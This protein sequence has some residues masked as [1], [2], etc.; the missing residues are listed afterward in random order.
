V[1]LK[2]EF[3]ALHE[4]WN[5]QVGLKKLESY[6]GRSDEPNS[7]Y[8][9][10]TDGDDKDTVTSAQG[11]KLRSTIHSI[12]SPIGY[13]SRSRLRQETMPKT[14][15]VSL[16]TLSR[17]IRW[18]DKSFMTP[19]CLSLISDPG[20]PGYPQEK[21]SVV[22]VPIRRENSAESYPVILCPVLWNKKMPSKISKIT[23]IRILCLQEVHVLW[24]SVLKPWT[25]QTRQ[26]IPNL[27]GEIKENPVW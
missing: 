25:P 15:V 17:A 3:P 22:D 12:L 23:N 6:F 21:V 4:I 11:Y 14:S 8:S 16:Q 5:P 27:W 2:A 18:T 19:S 13:R 24:Q 7:I 26:G 20:T 9:A 1:D 10:H